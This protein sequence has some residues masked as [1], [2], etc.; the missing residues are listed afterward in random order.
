M[1][2]FWALWLA[3]PSRLVVWLS[4]RAAAWTGVTVA[5]KKLKHAPNRARRFLVWML[6]INTVAWLM[7]A[8]GMWC[9]AAWN[10][11]HVRSG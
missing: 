2:G 4:S 8:G 7:F 6:V 5:W 11:S 1:A 3:S 10:A 9:L